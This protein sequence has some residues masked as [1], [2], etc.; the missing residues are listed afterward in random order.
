MKKRKIVIILMFVVGVFCL[1]FTLAY[2]T[3]SFNF[4]NNF[5]TS[6]YGSN[7]IEEFVSPTDWTP[8]DVTEKKIKVENS[9]S[10]DEAV[11]VSYTENWTSSNSNVE[12]NLSLTQDGN[13]ASLIKWGNDNDWT[14]VTENNKIYKYYNY[15]LN[16]NEVTSTVIE[17]VTFNPLIT[18]S[19]SCN[20]VVEGN[21]RKIVCTS[22]GNGYDNATYKLVFNIET[23]QYDKY[24]NIWNTSVDILDYKPLKIYSNRKLSLNVGSVADP[25]NY[26]TGYDYDSANSV[27]IRYLTDENNTVTNISICKKNGTY[28]PA[29]CLETNQYSANRAKVL[30]YFNGSEVNFPSNCTDDNSSGTNELTCV[31]DHIVIGIDEDEGI[32]I[33]D[34]ENG[35]SCVVMAMLGIFNCQ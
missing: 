26:Q 30:S 22:S 3:N 11:R 12:G 24:K 19:N 23:V 4:I 27:H 5:K 9:G 28:D 32:F 33:N 29:I 18:N 2:F 15:K 8:G 6:D 7:N 1:G 13:R 25:T 31:G 14:T 20:T 17:S 34:T 21:V 16:P 35:K 10:V